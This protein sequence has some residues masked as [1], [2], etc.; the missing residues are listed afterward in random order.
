MPQGNAHDLPSGI[1]YQT[2][3]PDSYRYLA[4]RAV[5]RWMC[6]IGIMVGLVAYRSLNYNYTMTNFIGKTI[7]LR[8]MSCL[9]HEPLSPDEIDKMNAEQALKKKEK[10]T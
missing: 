10:K 1:W 8:N 5:G 7:S 6:G 4:I 2:P 3:L 9:T